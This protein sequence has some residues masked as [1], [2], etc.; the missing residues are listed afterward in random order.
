MLHNFFYLRSFNG[1][2]NACTHKSSTHEPEVVRLRCD[3]LTFKGNPKARD[4]VNP[5]YEFRISVDEKLW[6]KEESYL[7]TKILLNVIFFLGKVITIVFS[8]L[9]Y[10]VGV[11]PKLV[12]IINPYFVGFIEGGIIVFTFTALPLSYLYLKE[13]QRQKR[14]Q[15][16]KKDNEK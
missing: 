4:K 2:R 9:G 3:T 5:K 10:A 16:T 13:K 14:D 8:I 11:R 15:L 1:T 12:L 6:R 7:G